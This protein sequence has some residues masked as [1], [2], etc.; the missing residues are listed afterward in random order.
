MSGYLEHEGIP[1]K[2]LCPRCVFDRSASSRNRK[3]RFI[4]EMSLEDG[5]TALERLEQAQDH[6]Y[7]YTDAPLK[8]QMHRSKTDLSYSAAWRDFPALVSVAEVYF[9]SW[10]KPLRAAGIDPN[11]YFVRRKWRKGAST[12]IGLL[13]GGRR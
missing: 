1:D 7:P 3:S 4:E 5:C 12:A 2:N 10:G 6:S 13:A 9:G 8:T 11:L